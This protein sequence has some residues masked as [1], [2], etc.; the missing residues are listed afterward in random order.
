MRLERHEDAVHV[1]FTSKVVPK[2]EAREEQDLMCTLERGRGYSMGNRL[3]GG[4]KAEMAA[5]SET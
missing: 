2:N 5:T 4:L 3:E 1:S